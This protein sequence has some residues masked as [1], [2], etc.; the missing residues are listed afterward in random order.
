MG[1][2]MGQTFH[3]ETKLS[4]LDVHFL[5]KY[6]LLLNSTKSIDFLPKCLKTLNRSG[7]C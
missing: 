7:K 2:I 4:I 5:I 3:T 6:S 1:Q